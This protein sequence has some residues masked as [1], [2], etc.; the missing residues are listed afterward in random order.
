M[1]LYNLGLIFYCVTHHSFNI[2]YSQSQLVSILSVHLMI[3]A[4]ANNLW[5]NQ[6]LFAL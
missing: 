3:Y 6:K 5:F 4:N 2:Q 1:V